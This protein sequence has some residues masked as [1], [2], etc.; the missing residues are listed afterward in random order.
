M[1]FW[2][3]L[4]DLYSSKKEVDAFHPNKVPQKMDNISMSE[5]SY[6][7]YE[8]EKIRL[9]LKPH[10]SLRACTVYRNS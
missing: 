8:E 10:D 1:S 7:S 4:V 6:L 3:R 9:S 2:L 5:H